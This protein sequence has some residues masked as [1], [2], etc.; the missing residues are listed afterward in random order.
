MSP[1]QLGYYADG[2][3]NID[4]GLFTIKVGASSAD[5]RL[6]G[7]IELTGEKL[8]P[9]LRSTYFTQQVLKEK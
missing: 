6:K 4:P 9:K 8:T 7:E 1:E 3:W 5:I 2:H